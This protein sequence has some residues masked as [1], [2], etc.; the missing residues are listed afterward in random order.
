MERHDELLALLEDKKEM[1]TN[2]LIAHFQVSGATIR[3][4]LAKLEEENY[5]RRIHGG[6]IYIGK[7]T[8]M[9]SFE[10]FVTRSQTNVREKKTIA[11]EAIKMIADSSTIMMDAS[12][13]VLN[14]ANYLDSFKRLTI[15]TN[16]IQ[17]AIESQKYKRFHTILVGGTLRY[18]STA[19]EG[20]LGSEI[21]N[22]LNADI[23]FTSAHG[24]TVESGLTDFNPYEVELKSKMV[25]RSNK[26]IALLDHR[27]IGKT[28]TSAFCP[29][30]RIHTIITDDKADLAY[31]EKIRKLGINVIIA[32]Y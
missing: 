8:T 25:E 11:L 4:D 2:E 7:P 27:K 12:S 1:T 5:I 15:I 23:L 9:E 20:L 14:M 32:G 19:L 28:S 6:A 31:I 18:N 22:K 21:L 26:V 3:G 30:N 16:G 29:V 10:S 17:T 13:T 24:F